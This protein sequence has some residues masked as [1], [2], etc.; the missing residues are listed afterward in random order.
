MEPKKL[1]LKTEERV[2]VAIT[3]RDELAAELKRAN[4]HILDILE[5]AREAM[6]VPDDWV[7]GDV[8][9]G[10]MPPPPAPGK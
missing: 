6:D 1:P 5:T 8:T 3:A 2:I 4:A 9:K 10:F 7:I